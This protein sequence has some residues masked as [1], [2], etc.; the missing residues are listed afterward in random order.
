MKICHVSYFTELSIFDKT[1]YFPNEEKTELKNMSFKTGKLCFTLRPILHVPH[2]PSCY[3]ANLL[4]CVFFAYNS[5]HRFGIQIR[6]N[7]LPV[8][9]YLYVT[10][11]WV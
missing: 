3:A 6:D 9:C 8:I 7:K 10:V 5:Y 1:S 4:S 2:T 11:W